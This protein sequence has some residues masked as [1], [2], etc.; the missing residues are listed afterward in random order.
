MREEEL[1]RHLSGAGGTQTHT[2]TA[3]Q[4]RRAKKGGKNRE[5]DSAQI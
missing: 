3:G 4:L 5:Q 1:I 2:K